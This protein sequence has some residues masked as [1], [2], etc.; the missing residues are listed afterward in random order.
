[1]TA[2]NGTHTSFAVLTRKEPVLLVLCAGWAGTP[3]P[4][5]QCFPNMTLSLPLMSSLTL[6]T[7]LRYVLVFVCVMESE[8]MHSVVIF[9][10]LA[11]PE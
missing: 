10:C 8:V 5:K 2:F 6:K 7:S 9:A 4:K 1:M 3:F 11:L